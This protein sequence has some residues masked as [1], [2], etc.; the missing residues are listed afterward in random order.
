MKRPVLE[1]ENLSV[2]L[3]DGGDRSHAV[4]GMTL[5]I[6]KGEIV[7]LLGESGSGKSVIAHAIMGL[8]PKTLSISS[9][10]I[11]VLGEDVATMPARELRKLRGNR[12]SMVFQ[13]PMTALNPVVRCGEQIEELLLIHG[14]K[15]VRARKSKAMEMLRQVHFSEPERVY[16]SYP[17][18]L[19]GGQR[20]RVMIALALC[21]EPDLLICD[22]PTTALDVT[23]QAEILTL[24]LE[25]RRLHGTAI[26]FITHDIGV[27]RQIADKV[28]VMRLGDA[29]EEGPRDVVLNHPGTDY[30]R[31]LID[32]V[33]P[34]EPARAQGSQGQAPVL[35]VSR[36]FNAYRHKSG[37]FGKTKET[38]V[39][40]NVN[41]AIRPGETV[42][43]VGES[44]SG[45]SSLAR[46]IAGLN[47][48]DSG[49]ILI[50]GKSIAQS[51]RRSE[52]L[53]FRQQVQMVFQDPY[54]SLN[55][56]RS[57][58]D[59]M[60]EGPMNLGWTR[61]AAVE[62][63]CMLMDR[64]R[65]SR[66]VLGRYP[67]E[68]SGGQRQRICIARALACE[69]RLLIADEAVSALDVSVQKQIM[70]L[71]E[72]IQDQFKLAMLFITHDLRVA[73][74]LCDR[75][76]VMQSGQVVEEG[77]ARQ[78]LMAPTAEYTMQLIAAIPSDSSGI[79]NNRQDGNR[80]HE[81]HS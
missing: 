21:L 1:I 37:F 24:V 66:S 41:L 10:T 50:G 80:S 29:I 31:M 44:G 48:F 67:H 54:R 51:R 61:E 74:R 9:G 19:S 69:P 11:K 71:L 57:I 35:E 45:K 5:A 56:R 4:N 8:L 43:V 59:S 75:I 81:A 27:A 73:A 13:E 30:T 26:L 68:F 76:M 52:E 53:A 3:P 47:S 60:I 32:A 39:A 36:L 46:C 28:V 79:G 14:E 16:R 55:P 42:G 15:N 25:L 17:H 34:L 72:E 33:P 18:Q 49:E 77:T 63:A 70:D 38:I 62:K 12:M 65:L 20:Q 64:V 78:V 7:C 22:E 40:D 2:E 58:L 23:T 6:G